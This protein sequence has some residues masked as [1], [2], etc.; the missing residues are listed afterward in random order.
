MST[1]EVKWVTV[2]FKSAFVN[3][4]VLQVAKN[5]GNEKFSAYVAGHRMGDA[6]DTEQEAMDAALKVVRG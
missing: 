3:G 6:Y 1:E 2:S 4:R 5:R